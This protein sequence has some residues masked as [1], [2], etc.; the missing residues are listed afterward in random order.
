MVDVV[1]ALVVLNVVVFIVGA[2]V[3]ASNRVVIIVEP[4]VVGNSVVGS[5]VVGAYTVGSGVVGGV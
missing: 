2:S 5:T 4:S 1:S 3:D